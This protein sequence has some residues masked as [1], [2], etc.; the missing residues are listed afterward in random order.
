MSEAIDL[1]IYTNTGGSCYTKA[2][3]FEKDVGIRKNYPLDKYI[4]LVPTF[5][6]I[7]QVQFDFNAALSSSESNGI[8]QTAKKKYVAQ[9]GNR[10]SRSSTRPSDVSVRSS[11]STEY[12]LLPKRKIDSHSIESDLVRKKMKGPILE[13]KD[14]V[15]INNMKAKDRLEYLNKLADDINE[16]K[17]HKEHQDTVISDLNQ[18]LEVKLGD[19]LSYESVLGAAKIREEEI[20]K[21]YNNT[22]KEMTEL[23]KS[24]M[25]LEQHLQ[26]MKEAGGLNRISLTS[27]ESVC[28]NSNICK[29]L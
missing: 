22:L 5:F 25:N 14:I 26:A 3:V 23:K 9:C 18:K 2:D 28:T 17:E 20:Q 4:V 11:T 12:Q 8:E 7:Q 6:D 13:M 24:N 1:G 10:L 15:E 16:Y 19:L 29:Q 21:K 27:K